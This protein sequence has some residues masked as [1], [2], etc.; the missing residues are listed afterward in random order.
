MITSEQIDEIL[1]MCERAT[2]GEWSYHQYGF[3]IDCED[4]GLY[5]AFGSGEQVERDMDFVTQARTLLPA[6]AADY[7][8]MLGVV[9]AAKEL[10]SF[11]WKKNDPGVFKEL[12]DALA[13]LEGG[14]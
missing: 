10:A 7:K 2:P 13:A 1:A 3:S 4:H 12:A 11:M 14:R 8:A 6:L 9:E 5:H